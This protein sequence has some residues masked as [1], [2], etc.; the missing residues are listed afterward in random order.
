MVYA[1]LQIV[2]KYGFLV[3]AILQI[4]TKYVYGI[5]DLSRS[6]SL[7]YVILPG[8]RIHI[9]VFY[10]QILHMFLVYLILQI[11]TKYIFGIRDPTNCHEGCFWYTRSLKLSQYM[12]LGMQYYKLSQSMFMVHAIGH[13]VCLWYTWSYICFWYTWSYKLSQSIFLV[14]TILQIVMKDVLCI[15]DL[16]NCH[17]VY[18]LHGWH[19]HA[20]YHKG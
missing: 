19:G 10:S 4:V 15:S 3:Y 1:I 6:M 5:R 11:V 2:T 17:K 12:F 8:N 16:T 20:Y 9:C 14:Y 18:S 13:E 7:I